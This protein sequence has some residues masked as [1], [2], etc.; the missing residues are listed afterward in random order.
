[1][2]DLI[3]SI[4]NDYWLAVVTSSI[5]SPV[6]AYLEKHELSRYFDDIMG[7]DIHKSKVRKIQMAL[8]KYDLEPQDALFITD[9]LG[10]MREA[11][12]A[13]VESIG[14]TWGFHDADHLSRGAPM[15][16]VHS[17]QELLAEI[18]GAF[19]RLSS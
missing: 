19:F 7:A 16:L 9:T 6:Q 15:A 1:M 8:K 5:N 17:P 11:D 13:A 3:K 10:D 14:V 4:G 2:V 12:K 18:P